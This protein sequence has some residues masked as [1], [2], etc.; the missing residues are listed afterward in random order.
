LGRFLSIYLSFSGEV[1]QILLLA[2]T[3]NFSR[4]AENFTT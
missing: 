3:G 1:E 2:G 4:E